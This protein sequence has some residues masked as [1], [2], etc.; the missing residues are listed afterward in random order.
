MA[1]QMN[2]TKLKLLLSF[3][4]FSFENRTITK[5]ARS[6]NM[7][8]YEVSRLAVQLSEE[9]LLDREDNRH[10]ILTEVGQQLAEKYASRLALAKAHLIYEGV[11]ENEA[12]RDA[13]IWTLNCTDGTFEAIERMEQHYI[14]KGYFGSNAVFSGS[15]LCKRI[16]NGKFIFPFVIYRDNVKNQSNI[17]MANHGFRHPCEIIVTN[18][19][20]MV[21]LKPI[22]MIEKSPTSGTNIMGKVSHLQYFN[23]AE[24]IEAGK[25]EQFVCIPM[26]SMRF[27]NIGEDI[28]SRILHGSIC[29][30]M[31]CT[32]G[33]MHM[34][35]STAIFTLLIH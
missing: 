34:P 3:H 10:P 9:G 29:L 19:K 33:D 2:E 28:A 26:D 23:G 7:E 16:Y 21:Y 27:I 30:K 12:E 35:E 8:K 1:L 32:A 4:T 11:P 18:G 25:Q 24:W 22:S 13:I 14:I 17:S 5:I 20:G 15:D 6:L 31:G